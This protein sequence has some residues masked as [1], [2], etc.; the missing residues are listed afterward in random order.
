MA[1][2]T[3]T[4]KTYNTV[5]DI[6]ADVRREYVAAYPDS[7]IPEEIISAVAQKVAQE[8][9]ADNPQ[10]SATRFHEAVNAS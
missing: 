8:F 2:S 7:E 3:W 1:R 4:S 10:F 6:L 5:A 9:G